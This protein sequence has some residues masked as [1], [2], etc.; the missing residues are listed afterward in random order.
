[1]NAQSL[2]NPTLENVLQE[3]LSNEYLSAL[4]VNLIVSVRVF[5]GDYQKFT[6]Q[7][8]VVSL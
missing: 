3:P 1:M 6:N 8:R 4:K 7:A 5:P 2:K